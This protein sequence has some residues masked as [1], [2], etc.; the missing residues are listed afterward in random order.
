MAA[1][2]CPKCGGSGFVVNF[3]SRRECPFGCVPPRAIL[4]DPSSEHSGGW[5]AEQILKQDAKPE[6]KSNP[7]PEQPPEPEP[8]QKVVWEKP[9]H[10]TVTGVDFADPNTR[11]TT[12]VATFTITNSGGVTLVDT[13]AAE[14]TLTVS[15][16]GKSMAFVSKMDTDT[17][18]GLPIGGMSAT[19]SSST[20]FAGKVAVGQTAGD[21]ALSSGAHTAAGGASGLTVGSSNLTLSASQPDAY[22]REAVSFIKETQH[23]VGNIPIVAPIVAH[24]MALAFGHVEATDRC[25]E[26]I[27]CHPIDYADFR[28]MP[29]VDSAPLDADFKGMLWGAEIYSH[30]DVPEGTVIVLSES[31]NCQPK[32]CLLSVSR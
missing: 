10:Q 4:A 23:E 27:Y 21:I 17:A 5:I 9:D 8:E 14:G 26:K 28:T 22:V 18:T 2:G 25:V 16:D 30:H 15:N 12:A 32:F 19:I 20:S 11:D 7:E 3:T 31:Q 6:P 29:E 13:T 24:M 1:T